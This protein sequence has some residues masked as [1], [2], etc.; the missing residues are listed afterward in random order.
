MFDTP[1]P[2]SYN[3]HMYGEETLAWLLQKFQEEEIWNIPHSEL[4][5]SKTNRDLAKFLVEHGYI[6]RSHAPTLAIDDYI[7]N[8]QS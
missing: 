8:D 5:P 3:R 1:Y 2:I 4:P 7:E 6:H